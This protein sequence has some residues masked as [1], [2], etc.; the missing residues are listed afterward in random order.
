[1][2]AS[3]PIVKRMTVENRGRTPRAGSVWS[4]RSKLAIAYIE[5]IISENTRR[6]R[7]SLMSTSVIA[8]LLVTTGLAPKTVLGIEFSQIK[9]SV[10]LFVLAAVI[11]YLLVEFVLDGLRD[12][13]IFSRKI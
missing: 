5:D 1:M 7:R 6:V 9:K 3:Q 8:F 4:E 12:Y 10:L 11:F 2:A 13:M